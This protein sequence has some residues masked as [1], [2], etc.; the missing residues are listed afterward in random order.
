MEEI[1]SKITTIT[2]LP[3]FLF[4]LL[5]FVVYYTVSR[6]YRWYVLLFASVVF[7]VFGCGWQMSLMWMAQALIAW[8]GAL[9]LKKYSRRGPLIGGTVIG[10]ELAA[11]I[12]MKQN[13]FFII[14]ARKVAGILGHPVEI[15]YLNWI[16]PIG[17]SYYTL[18][19]VSYILD[20]IWG[21][22]E[23]EKNP[24]KLLLYAGFFPQMVSGPFTRWH[25]MSPQL[26]EGHKF[27]LQQVQ[28]G[29]QRFL[30]GLSKKLILSERLA[31]I[32]HTIYNGGTEAQLG[33]V[34]FG[35]VYIFI[36][37]L[38]YVFQLYTDFS[39]CMDM[40][41][42]V[43]QIFGITLPENF[44]TPFYATNFSE[45]W[46]RWHITLGVWAK[47]YIMYP[48]L[49]SGAAERLR[50]LLKQRLG[51]KAAKEYPSYL[52][53]LLVWLVIGFWHGGNYRWIFWGL[54]TFMVIVGGKILQ[55]LFEK[56]KAMLHVNTK[57]A[58][59]T[60]FIRLRTMFLFMVTVSVQ[61]ANS[62]TSALKMWGQAFQYNP[63]VL[64]DGSLYTLGLDRLDFW[65]MIFGLLILFAV[66]HYQQKGSVREI[67]AKQNLVFRWILWLGLLAAVL[68][69]GLYGEGYNAADFI[70]GEF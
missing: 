69:F 26:F 9:L 53:T 64:V 2:S 33:T 56:G 66:S 35:G 50:S 11:L 24:L 61:P 52:G 42:G 10:I 51:K 12:L 44:R 4:V 8:G 28:F 60:L 3:F 48:F 32:V 45:F 70:Y 25:E 18:M 16:A 59:W 14:N 68:L 39:G 55:P 47:D 30:W 46:R 19:L 34:T 54:L 67:I 40:V 57:A 5:V 29:L 31:I 38:A 43:A 23:P 65:V 15:P 7:F 20:T 6:M 63:W 27:S 13:S 36:G 37:A 22:N 62:L 17:M 1:L 21:A 49:K 58:S 41:L